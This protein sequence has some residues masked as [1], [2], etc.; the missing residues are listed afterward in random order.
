MSFVR[1]LNTVAGT[2]NPVQL[3]DL[4]YLWEAV[5]A[6]AQTMDPD[7]IR[8]MSGFAVGGS[9]SGSSIGGGIICFQN[10]AYILSANTATVGQYLYAQQ[11]QVEQRVYEDGATRY[12]YTT[13][14]VRVS[15]SATSTG[16]GVLIGQA[17]EANLAI[18][19]QAYI[20]DGTLPGIKIAPASITAQQMAN[21][22]VN[23]RVIQRRFSQCLL[24]D[25]DYATGATA[26]PYRAYLSNI[27]RYDLNRTCWVCDRVS[28]TSVASAQNQLFIMDGSEI[29]LPDFERMP[30]IVPVIVSHTTDESFNIRVRALGTWDALEEEVVLPPLGGSCT[31]LYAKGYHGYVAISITKNASPAT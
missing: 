5:A 20:A 16:I 12:M 9:G 29:N 26:T 1:D 23:G 10:N 18:W 24:S 19:K 7:T 3:Q 17:T 31:I 25:S 11:T 4:S 2:G 22:A 30:F 13:Y 14:V 6:L 28:V 21:E 27:L 8:I 15:N